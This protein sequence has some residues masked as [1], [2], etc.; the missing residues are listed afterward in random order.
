MRF[1]VAFLMAGAVLGAA[2]GESARKTAAIDVDGVEMRAGGALGFPAVGQLHKG[3]TVIVVREE[4]T[5]FL[6]VVPP[7][8]S[9]S[10]IKLIQVG[11]LGG[12]ET[13]KENVPVTVDGAEVMAGSDK[14]KKPT[15][16]VTARLPKGTIIEVTGPAVRIDNT[17]WLPITPPEGDLRWVPKS[18]VKAGSL[19]ALASP[20]PY[21]HDSS[22]FTI[23]SADGKTPP[24]KPVTASLPTALTEHRLWGQATQAEKGGDYSTA[25]SLYARIYQDL[26][27]QKAER[28]AIV[29][30]YNRYVRCNEMVKSGSSGP[31]RTR[32]DAPPPAVE[33]PSASGAKWS[34]P[35]YLQELQ[36][37]YVDGQP[38]FSLQDD[39]GTV[40]DYVTAVSGINLHNYVGKR[41]Q[42]YG[43][44]STR[45]ELYKPH[46]LVERVEA[47]R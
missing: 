45:P 8:S 29:I 28:D 14:D 15:N 10:W 33:S 4:D 6:A 47:A 21:S 36:K 5:G 2:R 13:G 44:I 25:K 35:G 39:R 7:T 46:I 38:V 16:C 1:A 26:W 37:V 20:P 34:N 9:V 24:A 12:L 32:S 43:T 27:D 17:S 18:A 40:I 3:D 30:C 11:K 41:V 23:P 19:T 42:L 22:T 31:T